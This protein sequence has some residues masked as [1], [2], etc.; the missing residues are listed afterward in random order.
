VGAG[1]RFRLYAGLERH[2][3]HAAKRSRLNEE[4]RIDY[5]TDLAKVKKLIKLSRGK[6]KQGRG[7]VCQRRAGSGGDD[8][9]RIVEDRRWWWIDRA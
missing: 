7:L 5:R 3:R 9:G 8:Q 6:V 1:G 2:F 4:P